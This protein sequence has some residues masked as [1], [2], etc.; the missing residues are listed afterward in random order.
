MVGVS[1]GPG[2]FYWYV[3]E[4]IFILCTVSLVSEDSVVYQ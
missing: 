2:P 3:F 4:F 1:L